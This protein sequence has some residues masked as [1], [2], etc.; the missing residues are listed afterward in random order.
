M[1]FVPCSPRQTDGCDESAAVSCDN[2]LTRHSRADDSL[3]L[4]PLIG[5]ENKNFVRDIRLNSRPINYVGVFSSQ[6]H[7]E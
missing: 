6:G 3:G 5:S 7:H 4:P 1:S 2:M